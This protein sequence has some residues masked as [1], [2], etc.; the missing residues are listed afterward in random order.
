MV[1]QKKFFPNISL[2][3]DEIYIA[4]LLGIIESIDELS[5]LQITKG[6]SGYKFRLAPSVPNYNEI[7]LQEILK[8]HNQLKIKLTLSKSMK[9]SSVIFFEIIL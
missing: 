4:H 1:V 3:N 9:T 6:T 8:F 7:L 2:D 5:S